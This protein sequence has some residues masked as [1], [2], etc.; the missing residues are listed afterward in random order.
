MKGEILIEVTS[1]TM[2]MQ[3]I[4]LGTTISL[5]LGRFQDPGHF[6]PFIRLKRIFSWNIS[7]FDNHVCALTI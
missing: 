4:D 2:L 3:T 6:L 1:P 7:S 5:P